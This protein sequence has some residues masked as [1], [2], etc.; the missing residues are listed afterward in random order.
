[1]MPFKGGVLEPFIEGV[2]KGVVKGVIEAVVQ[3]VRVEEVREGDD[4]ILFL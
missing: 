3:G 1:M 4:D 2:V